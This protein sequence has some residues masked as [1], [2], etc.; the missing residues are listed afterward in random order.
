MEEYKRKPG[1]NLIP[2][3]H[4]CYNEGFPILATILKM[5]VCICFIYVYTPYVLSQLLWLLFSGRE[6]AGAGRLPSREVLQLWD[7]DSAVWIVWQHWEDR[8]VPPPV[9]RPGQFKWGSICSKNHRF[10][11]ENVNVKYSTDWFFY[12][13]GLCQL[14]LYMVHER[15]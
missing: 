8:E 6:T 15:R 14:S 12:F 9:L 11:L 3:C 10:S 2:K 4:L 13:S 1:W 7:L 5:I